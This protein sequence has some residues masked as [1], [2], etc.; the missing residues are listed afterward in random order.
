[1][2]KFYVVQGALSLGAKETK[3]IG[4]AV[5]LTAEQ[6][7]ELVASGFLAD[8][9]TFVGLKKMAEGALAAGAVDRLSRRDRKFAVAISQKPKEGAK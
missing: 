1:M 9:K 5:D 8:E 6:A 4:D 7:S 3:T 2:A